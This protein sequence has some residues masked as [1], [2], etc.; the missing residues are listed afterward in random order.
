MVSASA[1][2]VVPVNCRGTIH[3]DFQECSLAFESD[4]VQEV[5]L[6][7]KLRLREDHVV[8][9]QSCEE[10]EAGVAGSDRDEPRSE[11]DHE[12]EVCV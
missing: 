12:V 5:A 4:G 7:W 1:A 3:E 10:D 8:R 6:A 9:L 11:Q 2:H